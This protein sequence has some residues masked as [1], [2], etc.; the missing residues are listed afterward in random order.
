M[1]FRVSRRS[2]PLSTLITQSGASSIGGVLFG[3]DT[4]IN[5]G[6][7]VC[8]SF[9]ADLCEGTYD[10]D[11]KDCSSDDI[12]EQPDEWIEQKVHPRSTKPL[13]SG[14]SRPTSW[15]SCLSA[16]WS[17]RCLV[18]TSLISSAVAGLSR[19]VPSALVPIDLLKKPHLA[20]PPAPL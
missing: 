1:S 8:E 15:H 11:G 10:H 17:D 6:V 2:S 20:R 18:A 4:G 13:L 9:I 16:P 3:Y 7:Q 5:G 14:A 19:C 12:T